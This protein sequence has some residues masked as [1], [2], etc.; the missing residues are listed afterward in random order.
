MIFGARNSITQSIL[1][2]AGHFLNDLAAAVLLAYSARTADTDTT[3]LH[4]TLYAVLA[5]ATQLPFALFIDRFRLSGVLLR[6]AL[7]L[8]PLLI[9]LASYDLTAAI[10]L[11]GLVSSVYHVCG[12]A[13][14][15]DGEHNTGLRSGIFNAPGIIGLTAGSFILPEVAIWIIPAALLIAWLVNIKTELPQRTS[16]SHQ[17]FEWHDVLMFALLLVVAFRSAV[18]D[19]FHVMSQGN[20]ITLWGIAIAASVGKLGGGLLSDYLRTSRVLLLTLMSSALLLQFTDRSRVFLYVGIA[21][22]QASIPPAILAFRARIPQL[23]GSASALV[24]GF[25]VA[26]GGIVYTLDLEALQPYLIGVYSVLLA[27]V[28]FR[29]WK[30]K[31][32]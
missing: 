13:L 12:G 23:P 29:L 4:F 32:F 31:S 10:I 18:W 25:A 7:I 15:V 8:M 1:L 3:S 16:A 20:N 30:T 9:P 22:L 27:I 19:I 24:L 11:A 17:T 2:G 28:G 5:F 6:A 21:L 14:S 26:L